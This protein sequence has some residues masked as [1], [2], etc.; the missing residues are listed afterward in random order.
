MTLEEA[1]ARA[2]AGEV[3]AMMALGNYY[4]NN[5][6]S[7]D[8]INI[9]YE[10]YQKAAEAGDS[11]AILKMAEYSYRLASAMLPFLDQRGADKDLVQIMENSYKWTKKLVQS[12]SKLGIRGDA[13][14]DAAEFYI[15]SIV[16]LSSVYSLG[17]NYAG[18]KQITEGVPLP[19]AQALYGFALYELGGT[20]NELNTALGYL[21]AAMHPDFWSNNYGGSLVI[22]M[23]K[24]GAAS[25][26]S[27]MY[28]VLRRDNKAA[29]DALATCLKFTTNPDLRTALQED[30]SH[31]KKALFG[32]YKYVD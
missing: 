8:S 27:A 22:E 2:E 12:M 15:D 23:L 32:G 19:A 1:R 6:D 21:E 11:D 3:S 28:R 4:S 10:W 9:A 18:I 5:Q 25:T 14:N 29:H 13:L 31:Y 20:E 30:M 26:L 24:G 7:E 17:K 16:W